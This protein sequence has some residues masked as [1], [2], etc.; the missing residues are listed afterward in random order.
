MRSQFNENFAVILIAP[1]SH[2]GALI[3]EAI[4]QFNCAV[5]PQAELPRQRRNCRAGTCRQ[6]LESEQE[7]VLLRLDSARS[8]RFLAEVQKF[9]DTVSELGKLSKTDLRNIVVARFRSALALA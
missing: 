4:Y 2:Q 5:V 6:A 1:A 9:P 3:D 8:C 7:L